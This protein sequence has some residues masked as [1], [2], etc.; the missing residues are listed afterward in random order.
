MTGCD[1]IPCQSKFQLKYFLHITDGLAQSYVVG[2]Q[3][4]E[5][6]QR[7][8]MDSFDSE[9]SHPCGRFTT[10]PRQ[11]GIFDLFPCETWMQTSYIGYCHVILEPDTL[12]VKEVTAN[13]AFAEMGGLPLDQLTAR[14]DVSHFFVQYIYLGASFVHVQSINEVGL[15]SH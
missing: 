11:D 5:E 15:D 1:I 12:T 2:H 6:N 14:C 7:Q 10:F 8:V 4:T 3:K 13:Q 9:F